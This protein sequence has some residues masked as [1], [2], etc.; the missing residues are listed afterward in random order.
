MKFAKRYFDTQATETS[1]T[2]VNYARSFGHDVYNGQFTD[3][4]G[5]GGKKFNVITLW[6]VLEHVPDPS[7]L[8]EDIRRH[9]SPDGIVALAV[10]NEL[11]PLIG[12]RLLWRNNTPAAKHSLGAPAFGEE[13]HLTHFTPRVFKATLKR[14]G[15]EILDFGVDDT[16]CNRSPYEVSKYHSNRLINL[17]AKTHFDIAMF[18]ICR[19]AT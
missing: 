12:D 4:P 16:Y 3:F 11:T 6:H 15:F 19:L 13:I 18:S 2:G 9:L 17:I 1:T 14:H 7:K 10:P 8:L 5:R